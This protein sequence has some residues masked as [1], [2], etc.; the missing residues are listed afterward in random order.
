MNKTI[1]TIIA[2][3]AFFILLFT[4]VFAMSQDAQRHIIKSTEPVTLQTPTEKVSE[5]DNRS[6]MIIGLSL[7]ALI[8]LYLLFKKKEKKSHDDDTKTSELVG[9]SHNGCNDIESEIHAAIA[10][11]IHL[12]NE[13]LHDEE[14]TV[15]TINRISRTYSPWS[16]KIHGLNTYFNYRR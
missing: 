10:A 9:S 1:K 13:E 16:S 15:L 2:G 11:A 12:Y 7:A 3:M 6:G 4:G 14:N 8:A 5:I